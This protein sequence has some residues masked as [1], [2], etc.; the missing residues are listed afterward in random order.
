MVWWSA[1][2]GSLAFDFT[3]TIKIQRNKKK[4]AESLGHFSQITIVLK[5]RLQ[6]LNPKKTQKNW[7]VVKLTI[8]INANRQG[9]QRQENFSMKE[10]SA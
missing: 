6:P 9:A 8:E 1:T 2:H 7:K 4:M 5:R 3:K 10:P